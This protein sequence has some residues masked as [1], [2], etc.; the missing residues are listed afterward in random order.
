[1]PSTLVR[2]N[3]AQPVFDPS[4]PAKEGRLGAEGE[5]QARRLAVPPR[6]F[7]PMRLVASPEP[8][9]TRTVERSLVV[10]AH[11]TVISL[12]VAARNQIDGF[13]FWRRLGF[14][15]F[16]VLDCRDG[17]RIAEID[18]RLR[19]PGDFFGTRQAGLPDVRV[20]KLIRDGRV[21][22]EAR[23][24]ARA[25]LEADPWLVSPESQ[26]L[27]AVLAHRWAGRLERAATG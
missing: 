6:R 18:L 19:G 12:L 3:H 27:R 4:R 13:E 7:T 11:G 2:V 15:S 9:A 24:A 17:F 14:T 25:R 23:R 10:V 22:E 16:A 20:A 26:A 8:K 21:L 1:M 5:L